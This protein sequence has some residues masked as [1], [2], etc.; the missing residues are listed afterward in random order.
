MKAGTRLSEV[1]QE[2]GLS[3][4]GLQDAAREVGETFSS[5]LAGEEV[6]N[7]EQRKPTGEGGLGRQNRSDLGVSNP[8]TARSAGQGSKTSRATS[9]S[10]ERRDG[11]RR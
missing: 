1:A 5:A 10:S 7:S 4:E 2:R 11:G 9:T 8:Q 6:Q 3:K